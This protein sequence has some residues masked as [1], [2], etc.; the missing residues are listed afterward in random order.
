MV[1]SKL[2]DIPVQDVFTLLVCTCMFFIL[3]FAWLAWEIYTAPDDPNEPTDND[4]NI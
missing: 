4:C 2:H 3:I 1:L